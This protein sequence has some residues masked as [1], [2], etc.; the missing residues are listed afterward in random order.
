MSLSVGERLK[1]ARTQ[2]GLSLEDVHRVTKIQLN[3]LQ[4]IEEGR[5]EEV[6][7][8]AYARIFLKRYAT[9]LGLDGAVVVQEYLGGKEPTVQPSIPLEPKIE[10]AHEIPTP[11]HSWI[12]PAVLGIT[13][14]I[15][16]AFFIHLS[17]NLYHTLQQQR[18][19]PPTATPAESSTKSDFIVNP[20]KA[21][22]LGIH[23]T[24]RV[25]LQIKADGDVIF[26]GVL[27]KGAQ[28][29]W[30]AKKALEIWTGNA[31]AMRLFLNGKPLDGLGRGV[32][33]GVKITHQGIHIP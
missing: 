10:H 30:T 20:S 19:L 29:N 9:Y 14:L 4:A 1:A 8:P 11:R 23:T 5:L 13:G 18:N 6:L 2:K 27:P 26:Q 15:G 31:G 21:L 17:V 24:D 28:E 12:L 22:Q 16:M 7:N 33:K 3:I 32:K 25:W